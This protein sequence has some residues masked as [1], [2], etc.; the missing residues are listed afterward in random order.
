MNEWMNE[1][2]TFIQQEHVEINSK[3]TVNTFR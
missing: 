1:S 3:V 2:N